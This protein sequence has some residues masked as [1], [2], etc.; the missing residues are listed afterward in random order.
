MTRMAWLFASERTYDVETDPE[1]GTVMLSCYEAPRKGEKPALAFMVG[2]ND[3]DEAR[4][5]G[6]AWIE[7]GADA[8]I[9]IVRETGVAGI[10]ID[11][12]FPLH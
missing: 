12:R 2:C 6:D 4:K 10:E 7:E 11:P 8:V 1:F 3:H 9:R 5:L